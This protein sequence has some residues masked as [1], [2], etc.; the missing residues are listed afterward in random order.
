MYGKCFSVLRCTVV[1]NNAASLRRRACPLP[2]PQAWRSS[3]HS[4]PTPHP[5][6]TRA[7]TLGQLLACPHHE[8]QQARVDLSSNSAAHLG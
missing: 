7:Q 2:T 1:N 3:G 6:K 5:L 8:I 4:E